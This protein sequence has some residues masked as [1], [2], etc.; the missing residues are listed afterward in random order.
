MAKN[1]FSS[2]CDVLLLNRFAI[3][4]SV[5]CVVICSALFLLTLLGNLVCC[6]FSL[7]DLVGLFQPVTFLCGPHVL[8]VG[9]A[10]LPLVCPLRRSDFLLL[11]RCHC[12]L[13]LSRSTIAAKDIKNMLEIFLIFLL[14]Y[15]FV[16]LFRI[17]YK[18]ES[19]ISIKNQIAC[20]PDIVFLYSF[21]IHHTLVGIPSTKRIDEVLF[22]KNKIKRT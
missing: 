4:F 20:I 1:S 21:S 17:E 9:S 7:L 5:L 15:V 3:F 13:L 2:C 19:T 16:I 14:F 8:R 11:V 12:F 10:P 18:F 22:H 6:V